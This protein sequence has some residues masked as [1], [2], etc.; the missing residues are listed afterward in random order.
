MDTAAL[1]SWYRSHSHPDA[2]SGPPP[3]TSSSLARVDQHLLMAQSRVGSA[4]EKLSEGQSDRVAGA[5]A[6][7]ANAAGSQK[8]QLEIITRPSRNSTKISSSSSSHGYFLVNSSSDST[9]PAVPTR[10]RRASIRTETAE[11][12]VY[13]A[14]RRMQ[15]FT[16]AEFDALGDAL[17]TRRWVAVDELSKAASEVS[18]GWR[19][20]VALWLP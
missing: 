17:S 11:D 19:G 18:G 2:A 3:P 9:T 5:G 6:D 4:A 15:N 12:V 1:E 20:C 8:Q 14:V 16:R 7:D 13:A 10:L